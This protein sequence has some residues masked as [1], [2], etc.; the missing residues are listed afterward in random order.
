MSWSSS[1][2]RSQLP[3]DWERKRRRVMRRDNWEC[4]IKGPGCLGS[5]TDV[6]HVRRGGNHSDENLRAACRAC[7]SRKSSAEGNARQNELKALKKRP[8]ER[9][10]GAIDG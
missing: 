5:A 8:V 7:H 2:R 1:N 10:P 6:D 3:S 4:Q 9:H